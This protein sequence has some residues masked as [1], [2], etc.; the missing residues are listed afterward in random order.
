MPTLEK[1]NKTYIEK[2]VLPL[3]SSLPAGTQQYFWHK[4]VHGLGL[5]LTPQKAVYIVQRRVKNK[6]TRV[7]I[8]GYREL[9]TEEAED[10]ANELLRGM[11]GG[12]DP[13]AEKKATITA[14][15]T[16]E[17]A[18]SDYLEQ[19]DAK[20]R[21]RT[22]DVYRSAIRRCFPDWLD[23]PLSDIDDEKVAARQIKL[24]N[25]NG[26]RGKGEA[27]ANQAMRVLRTLFNYAMLTYKDAQK[28]PIIKA[29]PVVGLKARRLW[30]KAKTRSDLIADDQLC[31]W[32]EAVLRIDNATIRDYLI[33]CL[34]TGLRRTEAAR[35]T[36][37]AIRLDSD[38]P[39]L[40]IP[41]ADTK[42]NS[43]H[44]LPLSTE[45]VK[46]LLARPRNGDFVF[47]GTK[48]GAHIVEPKRAIAKVIKESGVDF[49][50]HTLR[51]TFATMAGKLDIAHYKHKMLMNHSM[52]E[53]VTG[54]HYVKLTVEDLREPMQKIANHITAL[55]AHREEVAP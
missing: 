29:N 33:L 47:P 34:F 9:T 4:H 37:S 45:L 41:A 24:S 26:P 18:L 39:I 53:E 32:Y 54:A 20:L 40:T 44:R 38:K 21:P 8:G 36:W 17:E 14:S 49:S 6:N 51:R 2:F 7:V 16:L 35:L 25:A 50:L 42:T 46:L 30:N 22:K 1:F 27:Q 11:R 43:E 19:Y 3:Q 5:K 28:Q 31:G 52:A 23:K 10:K 12:V 13:I 48:P 55:V 15:K